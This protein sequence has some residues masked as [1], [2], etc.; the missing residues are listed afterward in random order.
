MF[1]SLSN[2]RT[3]RPK[4]RPIVN[5]ASDRWTHLHIKTWHIL[6][7][8]VYSSLVY[9][10]LSTLDS[11]QKGV[12]IPTSFA[13]MGSAT[14]FFWRNAD[15]DA[16]HSWLYC[17]WQVLSYPLR[18]AHFL[19]ITT[20]IEDWCKNPVINLDKKVLLFESRISAQWSCAERQFYL[21]S[22][23]HPLSG[24]AWTWLLSYQLASSFSL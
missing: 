9:K 7:D 23:T 10:T 1:R 18:Y 12:K 6:I 3:K 13:Y 20:I 15:V 2:H 19:N 4:Y 17:P 21:K 14:Q 22:K 24:I 16:W 8:S 11:V 5:F